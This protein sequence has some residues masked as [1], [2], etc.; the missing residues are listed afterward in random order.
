AVRFL[1][2]REARHSA[3]LASY[4]LFDGVFADQLI[5][6]GRADARALG[7]AWA[8]F[9]SDEPVSAAEAAQL[10]QPPPRSPLAQTG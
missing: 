6:M 4:L 5:E 8:R 9:F 3:D 1:A 10:G 2:E 7:D